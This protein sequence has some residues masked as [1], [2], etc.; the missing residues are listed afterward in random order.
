MQ[1]IRESLCRDGGQK[2]YNFTTNTLEAYLSAQPSS[3]SAFMNGSKHVYV[4]WCACMVV[5][6][7]GGV[8]SCMHGKVAEDIGMV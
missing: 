6:M 5:C 2:P 4:G 3:L 1:C 8:H 7:Q